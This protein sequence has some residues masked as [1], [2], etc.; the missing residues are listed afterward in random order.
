[1]ICKFRNV[2]IQ[3]HVIHQNKRLDCKIYLLEQKKNSQCEN[4]EYYFIMKTFRSQYN[5]FTFVIIYFQDVVI[6]PLADV[7][8]TQ[9]SSLFSTY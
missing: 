9:D 5:K 1:M 8:Q 6:H 3:C 7:F 4:E 2:M